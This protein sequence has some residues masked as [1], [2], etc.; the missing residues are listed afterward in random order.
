MKSSFEMAR[1]E[2]QTRIE[3]INPALHDSGWSD[4]LIREERTPGGTDI[5]DGKPRKRKG[6]TDYLLC[7]SV[8]E[9]KPPLAVAVLEAKA[10]DKLPSLGIQ[11]A[12]DYMKK[13]KIPLPPTLD[14]Q[15]RIASELERKMAEIEKMRQAADNQLEAIEA[16]QGAILR[17]AFDFEEEGAS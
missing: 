14:D 16:L 2:K 6:R 1:D 7:I 4:A 13:F 12:K 11:Q 9:G 10:E 8:I 15:I 5:I 3:L 17:V